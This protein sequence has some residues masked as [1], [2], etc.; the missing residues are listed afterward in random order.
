[1]VKNYSYVTTLA[2]SYKTYWKPA[3]KYFQ[4]PKTYAAI[5]TSFRLLRKEN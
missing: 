2:T 5:G 3:I 1:M 4:T